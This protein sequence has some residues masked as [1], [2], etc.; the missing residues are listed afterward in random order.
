MKVGNLMITSRTRVIKVGI[1]Q[2]S[3]LGPALF[4][5][6]LNTLFASIP[7][8]I[9][10][11]AYADDIHLRC[12]RASTKLVEEDLQNGLNIVKKWA[13]HNGQSFKVKTQ[14]LTLPYRLGRYQ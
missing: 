3:T 12:T 11:R 14:T 13:D 2:G 1:P 8:G 4:N 9:T 10:V 6:H 7:R 5:I